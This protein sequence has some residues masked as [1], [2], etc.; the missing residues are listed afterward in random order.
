MAH[1]LIVDDSPTERH[2]LKSVLTENGYD[3]SLAENAEQGIEMAMSE[4]PDLILMDVV[5][6]GMNGFQATR[7]LTKSPKTADIPVLMVSTK[8]DQTDQVW[9]SRQGAKAY[10]TKPV[11]GKAL[12]MITMH[13]NVMASLSH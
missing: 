10:I 9:A 13:L 12:K 4:H 2:F 3:I 5:M 1:I 6:P 11:D 7:F 8:S